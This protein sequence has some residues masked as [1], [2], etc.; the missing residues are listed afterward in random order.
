MLRLH[1]HVSLAQYAQIAMCAAYHLVPMRVAFWLLETHDRTPG[2]RFYLTH[3]LLA[4]LL[5]V[6]SSGVHRRRPHAAA[7]GPDHVHRGRILVVDR[8]GLERASC[9]CHEARA[10]R[11]PPLLEAGAGHHPATRVALRRIARAVEPR[12]PERGPVPPHISTLR[13]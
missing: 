4:H 9:T 7:A 3:D 13:R 6:R 11:A 1:L 8:K 10:R 5:G 12:R 2:D